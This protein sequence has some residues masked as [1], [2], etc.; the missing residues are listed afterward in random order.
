LGTNAV[1]KPI[2]AFEQTR[3]AALRALEEHWSVGSLASEAR[4]TEAFKALR[5]TAAALQA[6][7]S[8]AGPVL[9]LYWVIMR[10]DMSNAPGVFR[11]SHSLLVDG[12]PDDQRRNRDAAR[13]CLGA[14]RGMPR[15][16]VRSIRGELSGNGRSQR[17]A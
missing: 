14:S 15:A 3:A 17:P 16:L 13:V 6:Y 12:H 4:A 5:E 11:G 7:G 1:G 9:R 8:G 2:L 10:Y